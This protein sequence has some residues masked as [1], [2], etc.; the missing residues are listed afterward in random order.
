MSKEKVMIFDTTLR[1]GEQ[2]AGSRLDVREKLE[3]AQQLSILGVD[4]IEA[5]FPISSPKDFDSGVSSGDIDADG[6]D[7]IL[8]NVFPDFYIIDYDTFT[9][10]Y[11]AIWHYRPNRSNVTVV[12]DYDGNGVNEF[13][14]NNGEQVIGF[15]R[16]QA[17]GGPPA[18]KVVSA[19]P[20]D[21]SRIAVSWGAV[22]E[23]DGYWIYFS[24]DQTTIQKKLWI[25]DS[26][27]IITNLL[28]DQKYFFAITT[29]DSSRQPVE[30]ALSRIVTATPNTQ[31]GLES[32]MAL[33]EIMLRVRFTENMSNSI[34]DPT[35]Y[36]I[37]ELLI[38]P[39]S[40]LL[41]KSG[42]E[43]VLT[44]PTAMLPEQRYTVLVNDVYDEMHTPID[45]TRDS[46]SFT[47]FEQ[48]EPPYL[49]SAELRNT[50][51]IILTFS[52]ELDLYTAAEK[53]NYRLDPEMTIHS[54]EAAGR[55]VTLKVD[56]LIALG[57]DDSQYIL[58]VSNVKS[59]DGIFI[60]AGRGDRVAISIT[61]SDLS[62]V[63]TYPNPYTP[64]SG[65]DG[66]TFAN[67]TATATI[68][69]FTMN[70]IPIRRLEETD[71]NGGLHWDLRNDN[72]ELVA[73]GVY[74]FYI[75]NGDD[76]KM[77]KLAIVR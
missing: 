28:K 2:A 10:V 4:I 69:I 20:L 52:T 32:A 18:P 23:S 17:S 15:E 63:F 19:S 54:A 49:K 7:E 65:A 37:A 67:L 9:M 30:S 6:R 68:R 55:S 45:T 14:F 62:D 8:L 76:E 59:T 61:R 77:G 31:P 21:T 36:T 73:G 25:T 13:Y 5:G 56:P 34:K 48:I 3:I 51:T 50:D 58:F 43:V 40:S 27:K 74:I 46:I 24:T 26:E 11:E 42:R 33:S 38:N 71:G 57:G 53:T 16:L 29:V 1:D 75:T 60:Q 47:T 44:L 39:S 22:D 66:I 41:D 12:G 70:G 35:K 72:G 64:D